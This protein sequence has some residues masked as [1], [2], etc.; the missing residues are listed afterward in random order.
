MTISAGGIGVGGRVALEEVLSEVEAEGWAELGVVGLIWGGGVDLDVA[1]TVGDGES[2][3]DAVPG[4]EIV[5]VC[6]LEG[7]DDHGSLS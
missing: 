3:G 7:V 1:G 4:L 2:W 5:A 6:V